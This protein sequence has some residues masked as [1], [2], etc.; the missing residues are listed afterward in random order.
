[1]MH[2]SKQFIFV[3]FISLFFVASVFGEDDFNNEL[4]KARSLVE[5][6]SYSEAL[7]IYS[8]ISEGLR[9]DPG[10]IIEWARVHTYADNHEE[11]I[12]LFEEVRSAHPER[13]PEVLRELADQYKWSSK[14]SQAIKVYKEAL[15]LNAENLQVYLGLAEAHFWNDQRNE[16][17]QIY[18]EALK[19]WPDNTDALLG[20]AN[21][22]SFQ[23]KLE[24]SYALYQ[25]VLDKDPGNLNALNS[26]ARILVW[27]GYHR[28]GISRYEKILQRYPKNPDAIEGMAFALHWLGDDTNAVRRIEELLEF[29]PNRK[30]AQDLY[31]QIK[32][33][34][35]LFARP[36]SRFMRDS[37]PQTVATGGLRSGL[38]LNRSTSID[39]IYEHQVLRKKGAHEP[40]LSANR[41]GIGLSKN[42]GNTY[43]FNTFLYAAHF[44]K[45][46]FNPFTTNTWL[47]YKPDDYWRFDLA[48]DRET[49]EDNDALFY[50]VITNSPSLSIDF[51][52][53]R[54]WFFNVKYKRSYFSDDNRQNQIFSRI[55]YRFSQKP[56]I[57]LYYNYYDSTWGEPE[58]SHGYFDP[59]SLRSHALGVYTGIDFTKKLFLEA[60]TSGGYE[61]QRKPDNAHKKSDHPT[62][63]AAASLNY[64]LT[65]NWL[66]S[67]SGDFFTTWPDHG[68]R[69][70][71]KRG[72]Y[73]SVT[74]NFGANP[75]TLRDATRPSR[76]TGAN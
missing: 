26:Q 63:S 56:Y 75:A 55:E 8:S 12:K 48:Y 13:S 30:E 31:S 39:G 40:T 73:L 45:I 3:F 60:K 50:K 33:S 11:A 19:R 76:T 51:K 24:E 27:Q 6:K 7:K 20:K 37:T 5:Q 10:L 36:Y 46:D 23:D 61:F 57:K 43:E 71:Q 53:N 25:K 28:K 2:R 64:R 67:A 49:F 14:T 16:A 18:D 4:S 59:R 22:L 1:M 21:I 29:E 68:Q 65:D 15:A 69:S 66:L 35:H 54:F 62:Y 74:Y 9:K 42:F 44:N 41:E 17:L 58:I 72:A 34:Q 32:D 70:Y 47:T 52:L 38:R